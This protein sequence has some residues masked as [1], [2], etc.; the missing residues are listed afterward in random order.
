VDV[1]PSVSTIEANLVPVEIVVVWIDIDR[2]VAM[3]GDSGYVLLP[4]EDWGDRFVDISLL[5]FLFES[6]ITEVNSTVG[7]MMEGELRFRFLDALD[8]FGV[9]FVAKK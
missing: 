2:G 9:D 3:V 6:T 1:E 4:L 8:C 7:A 5:M